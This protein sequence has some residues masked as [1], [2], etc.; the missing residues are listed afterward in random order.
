M[1]ELLVNFN[2]NPITNFVIDFATPNDSYGGLGL[3]ILK[4]I[5]ILIRVKLLCGN[6]FHVFQLKSNHTLTWRETRRKEI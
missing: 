6:A 4:M 3:A 5:C 2:E 1:Q